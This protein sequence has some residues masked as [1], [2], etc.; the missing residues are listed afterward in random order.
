MEG[1]K[2][3]ITSIGSFST[4]AVVIE[5]KKSG[6][7]CIGCDIY[8]KEWHYITKEFKEVYRVNLAVTENTYIKDILNICEIENINYI[9][10]STDIEIDVLNKNRKEFEKRKIKLCIQ[11]E[12]TLK[13]CRNKWNLYIE[14]QRDS[15]VKSIPTY[16]MKDLDLKILTDFPYIAK[17]KNGRSSEGIVFINSMKDFN[18]VDN[19]DNYIIQKFIKG[20]IIV[21][22]YIRNEKTKSDFC[23]LRKELIRTQNG[24][25][26]TVQIIKNKELEKIISYIGEK[27]AINGAINL[28]FIENNG[29]YYL[30]D[31]NPR[32]SA[33]TAFTLKAGYDI[34]S[35]HL[36]CFLGE[37]IEKG[38]IKI[39]ELLLCK[40]YIEEI[41]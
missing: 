27:I 11:N 33:G 10:P 30:M 16:L 15:L 28:E 18:K 7:I 2:I 20:R 35:N 26:L 6:Y 37:E 31:I 38:N 8:P 14:F 9:L 23:I 12:K 17:P 13:V 25:G 39:K 21:A 22:D 24:A 36:K 32:F 3:L 19:K 29:E 40:R 1:K 4:Q 41:L 5:L 34:V